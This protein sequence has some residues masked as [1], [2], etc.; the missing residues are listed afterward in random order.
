MRRVDDATTMITDSEWDGRDA[1]DAS[2]AIVN[3]ITSTMRRDGCKESSITTARHLLDSFASFCKKPLQ[4][5]TDEDYHAYLDSRGT[6]ATHNTTLSRL[7]QLREALGLPKLVRKFRKLPTHD[8]VDLDEEK[9]K[10]GKMLS[11]CKNRRDECLVLLFRYGGMRISE[12]CLLQ[13]RNF[14]VSAT[15]VTCRFYRPKTDTWSEVELVEPAAAIKLYLN[16]LPSAESW[17]FP[18][19]RDGVHLNK[20]SLERQVER[21]SSNAGVTGKVNPHHWRH[22]RATELGSSGIMSKWDLDNFFGWSSQGN[23][24]N[25]YVNLSNEVTKQK[26]LQLAGVT[27]VAVAKPLNQKC[28]ICGTINP[29][30]AVGCTRCGNAFQ[31]ARNELDEIKDLLPMMKALAK[32]FQEKKI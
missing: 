18:S 25:T 30:E 2:A 4:H 23:T 21:I 13:K 22:V 17:L 1:R 26:T 11:T 19:N 20:S 10:I 16:T 27:T 14:K 29:V 6:P 9:G 24:S 3:G 15:H 28:E 32:T 5:C 7:N 8:P 12:M 31:A